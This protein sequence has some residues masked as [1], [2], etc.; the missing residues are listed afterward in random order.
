M[1]REGPKKA[2]LTSTL[3]FRVVLL[4]ITTD[5]C[6]GSGFIESESRYGSRS[7]ISSESGSGSESR[8]RVLMTKIFVEK[9]CNCKFYKSFLLSK[10]AIFLSRGFHK[11]TPKQQEK[12][13]A[14]KREHPVLQKMKFIHCFLFFWVIF[15]LLDA[16]LIR[17]QIRIRIE[18]RIQTRYG[19]GSP[20]VPLTT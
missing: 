19:S 9:K 16:D 15:A 18:I 2:K 11:W 1:W 3:T 17:I 12:P 10:I 14:L 7:S 20:T 6:C 4:C 8:S 5:Q 13:S